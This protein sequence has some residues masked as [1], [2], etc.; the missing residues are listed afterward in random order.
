MSN[1]SHQN[2]VLQGDPGRRYVWQVLQT[3]FSYQKSVLER[4]QVEVDQLGGRPDLPVGEHDVLIVARQPLFNL[5]K[6]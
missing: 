5:L 2:L 1:F 6:K 3:K 4:D